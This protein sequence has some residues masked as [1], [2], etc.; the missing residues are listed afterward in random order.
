MAFVDPDS[1]NDPD[2]ETPKPSVNEAPQ[3]GPIPKGRSIQ[4][5]GRSLAFG[6]QFKRADTSK[7]T[8]GIESGAYE[9]GGRVTDA[10][11]SPALGLLTRMS[12]D[13]AL[14]ALGGLGGISEG[15]VPLQNLGRNVMIKALGP[16]QTDLQSGKAARAAQTMLDEGLNV[17]QGGVNAL[18]T[19]G[20][21]LN[22]QVSDLI[23]QHGGTVDKNAVAGRIQ[24]VIDRVERSQA[25]PQDARAAAE[26]V[27]DQFISNGLIPKNVPVGQAQEVKQGIYKMLKDKYGELGSETVESQKAIARGFKEEIEKAIPE[28]AD[29]NSE[30]SKLWNALNVAERKALIESRKHILGISALGQHPG[31]MLAMM[32][33]RSSAFKS[34]LARMIY[35]NARGASGAAGAATVPLS[36][37][38]TQQ[39][40]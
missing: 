9:L 19:K 40:Q 28:V 32:A 3:I 35:S 6:T 18:R 33:D 8:G 29:K 39:A 5:A 31:P 22:Q 30:A 16:L 37:I 11:G 12:P 20:E 38:A 26:R 24:D 36:E 4:S 23:A 15:M 25:T 34:L 14:S 21:A 13:I 27:Y 17:T 7:D 1:F 10:T 2:K